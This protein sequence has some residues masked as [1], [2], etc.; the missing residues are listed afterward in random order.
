[1]DKFTQDHHREFK[2]QKNVRDACSSWV[3]SLPWSNYFTL[4]FEYP[5]TPQ[6]AHRLW[7]RYLKR[8]NTDRDL[9]WFICSERGDLGGR[10]HLHGLSL[11][12]DPIHASGLN[13][14]WRS[15]YGIADVRPFRDGGGAGRYCS[16]YITIEGSQWDIGGKIPV[17]ANL[18]KLGNFQ[19]WPDLSNGCSIDSQNG[20]KTSSTGHQSLFPPVL[21]REN[22]PKCAHDMIEVIE[23]DSPTGL[24]TRKIVDTCRTKPVS[25]G[26]LI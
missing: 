23:L 10:V 25:A 14:W 3:E 6:Q 8:G 26:R 5:P 7:G 21:V 20:Q 13:G 16:K 11:F 9:S 12:S 15:R 19:D 4:T 18:D 2:R 24:R 1:M 22:K 17:Y